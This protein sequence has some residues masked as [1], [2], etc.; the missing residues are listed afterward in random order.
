MCVVGKKMFF[1]GQDLQ[2]GQA[3]LWVVPNGTGKGIYEV[4]G[5]AD[6]GV[7][8][9]PAG[10]AN[11][12]PHGMGPIDITAYKGKA[13]F[14]ASDN[15]I[16]PNTGWYKPAQG[17]WVSNGSAGGTVE[18]GGHGSCNH[19]PAKALDGGLLGGVANPD[20]KVYKNEVLFLGVD[21]KTAAGGEELWVTN[22]TVSGTR[23]I[24]GIHNAG[25]K[26]HPIFGSGGSSDSPNFTIFGGKVFF[27]AQAYDSATSSNEWAIWTTNGTAAGTHMVANSFSVYYPNTDFTV[28]K[29]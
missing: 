19:E 8:N 9:S 7:K 10:N 14:D 4:G 26:Q 25:I 15:T 12:L 16:N 6:K 28:G 13:M 3:G 1:A 21:D 2:D 22:G 20:F 24:G 11:N 18:L 17:L 27:T 5:Q 23:E 29:L